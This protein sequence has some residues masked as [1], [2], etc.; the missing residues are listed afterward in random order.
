VWLFVDCIL[1]T[2]KLIDDDDNEDTM[3]DELKDLQ[4]IANP[5][6]SVKAGLVSSSD[7]PIPLK[8]VHIRAKLIDMAAQVAIITLH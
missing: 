8:S 7:S 3:L 5:L 2:L 6:E 4:N 1:L